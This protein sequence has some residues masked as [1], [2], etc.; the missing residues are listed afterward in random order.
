MFDGDGS[1]VGQGLDFCLAVIFPVL[2]IFVVTDAE[3]AAGEDDGADVVVEAGCADC[4]LFLASVL[5][6]AQH[7][8]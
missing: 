8:G 5:D 3:G 1:F 6:N 4:F 2:D 7:A